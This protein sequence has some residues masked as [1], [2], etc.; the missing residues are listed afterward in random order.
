MN[1]YHGYSRRET[2]VPLNSP[3]D[4][5]RLLLL[6]TDKTRRQA[7]RARLYARVNTRASNFPTVGVTGINEFNSLYRGKG[8]H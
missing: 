4:G 3:V 5:L 6:R 7:Q 2:Q 1:K 8:W